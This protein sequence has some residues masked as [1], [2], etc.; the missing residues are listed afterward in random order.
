MAVGNGL[1]DNTEQMKAAL[2]KL[3]EAGGG[4]EKWLERQR[5]EYFYWFDEVP[6]FESSDPL[7]DH[8]WWY[9]WFMLRHNTARPDFGN[10]HH[11]LVY[12]GRSH[13]M[14]KEEY[15]PSGWEF[16]K[17]IPLSTP[18]HLTDLRWYGKADLSYE[19]A[20]SLCD[21]IDKNG[22]FRVLFTDG[23]GAEYA[24]YAGWALYRLCLVHR[25]IS[26][27]KEVL[28]CF[29]ANVRAVYK[30]HRGSGDHLQIE[31]NHRLTGKEYQPSYW[32]FTGYPDNANDESSYVALKRVDRSIYTYLNLLG[33]AYLCDITGDP[34]KTEFFTLAGNLR[35]DI[36]RKMWDGESGFFYDLHFKTDE[37]AP[38]KNIVGI[39]PLWAGISGPEHTRALDYL[40]DPDVFNTGSAFASTGRD[41][42]VFSADGGWKKQYFKGRNGC[43]WDGPSWPYTTGI[44]LD[45]IASQSKQYHL[46]LDN[47]FMKLLRSYSLQHFQGQDIRRPYLVEHYNSITG[48]AV[49]DEVDYN[50]SFYIDLI[51]RH[52]VGIEPEQ[53][54]FLFCPC[55]SDLK[56]FSLTALKLQGHCIDVYYRAA[57]KENS[58]EPAGISI[59]IDGKQVYE[60]PELPE[61]AVRFSFTGI[62]PPG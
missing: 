19:A 59:Y 21:S 32:Y 40:F 62:D 48:E 13:K 49:S 60:N 61:T 47:Q 42:P 31:T 37:K 15:K 11:T 34:D 2:L 51:I 55:R 26:F 9:R 22:L 43:M 14:G 10:F 16:S 54:G 39:Y 25:D 57:L 30:A 17:L 35:D 44:A 3:H 58:G 53:D 7:L 50:H 45:T 23:T 4:I 38:V 12:E 1:T 41:C 29:K 28:S 8:T 36:L 6:I 33:L 5:R 18:L 20:R 24:N 27:I 52:V 56:S 46:G